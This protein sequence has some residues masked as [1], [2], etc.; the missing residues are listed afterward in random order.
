MKKTDKTKI[1]F[2][3]DDVNILTPELKNLTEIFLYR[4]VPITHAVE[5]GNV[6]A[7]TISWLRQT[8]KK[9]PALLEI[10][11]HGWDH[12][13]HGKGEF[14][15]S[16]SYNE[17]FNDLKRGKEKLENIFGENFFSMITI[18]FGVYNKDTIKAASK[19]SYK[20]FCGHYNY[21]ISRRL[22]YLTG[23]I[24]R[25]GRLLNR[26]VS[27]HLRYYPGTRLF[28]I[29]SA[30]SFS[31]KY[32]GH[33]TN[34]CEMSSADEMFQAFENYRKI[35]PAVIFLLHHRFHHKKHDMELVETVL[36]KL[37]RRND[38]EFTNYN[39]L[40]QMFK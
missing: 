6:T 10:V 34:D 40:Y 23:R 26:H 19:L 2:R 1:C 12:T 5:P 20:V 4:K 25:K 32:F 11:Q 21:R 14:D 16:R 33:F 15:K 22:F 17:Q 38:I 29:D 37:K 30:I 8:K 24:M 31:K 28:E 13:P 18:P 7:D 9:Y 39:K 35:T 36:D 27:N 3:N